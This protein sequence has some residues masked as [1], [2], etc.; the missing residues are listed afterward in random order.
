MELTLVSNESSQLLVSLVF[1]VLLYEIPTR[2]YLTRTSSQP[3]KWRVSTKRHAA[4]LKRLIKHAARQ[5]IPLFINKENEI[6]DSS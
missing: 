1:S 2:D 4:F 5:I 6:R 3:D